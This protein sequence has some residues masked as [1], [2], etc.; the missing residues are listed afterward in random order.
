VFDENGNV[1]LVQGKNIELF[2]AA[3]QKA[4]EIKFT[5]KANAMNLLNM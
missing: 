4:R 5:G 3:R 1:Q 2:E